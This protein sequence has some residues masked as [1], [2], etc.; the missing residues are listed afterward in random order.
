MHSIHNCQ[1]TYHFKTKSMMKIDI[2]FCFQLYSIVCG[3]I[4]IIFTSTERGKRQPSRD[5]KQLKLFL[6]L[7]FLAARIHLKTWVKANLDICFSFMHHY[8][9]IC[10][11][12]TTHMTNNSQDHQLS[13]GMSFVIMGP[14]W[15]EP[16]PTIVHG[17][18]FL[19]HPVHSADTAM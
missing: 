6:Q 9:I 11:I 2:W 13:F 18:F 17:T 3:P 10:W 7:Q 4:Y 19:N 12:I 8:V 5:I 1:R 16:A 15:Q 14:K